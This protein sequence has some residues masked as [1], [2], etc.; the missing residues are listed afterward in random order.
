MI[1]SLYRQSLLEL[2]MQAR[3]DGARWACACAQI[4]L[5]LRTV[6]RWHRDEAKN[7]DR[8]VS[9]KRQARTPPN[10]LSDSERVAALK[11]LNSEE[12]KDLPPSQIVP[13]LADRGLYVASEST[14]Y[15]L[16]RAAGQLTHRRM[17]RRPKKR[18][19]PRAL[20][21]T[22]PD[23][24]YCWD[25]TY[26]PTDVRGIFFY[27]YLYV[28]LFSRQIVDWQVYDSECSVHASD[29]LKDICQ[30]RGIEPGQLSVH[31]DNGSPMKG[32]V[33]VSTMQNLGISPSR[34][35]PAVSNDNP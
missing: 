4:G 13:R 10:K 27:L 31:S 25:I 1:S 16:L 3:L 11:M 33:M 18:A 23:Q 32:E 9:D 34:S 12:F 6:Q 30:R 35:R 20:V 28:D 5:S 7:G 26:L 17:E 14:L 22:G 21:A 19:K 24:V 2:L 29:L 8:R 15:R